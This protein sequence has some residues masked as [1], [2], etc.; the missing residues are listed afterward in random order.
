MMHNDIKEVDSIE[1]ITLMDNLSDPFTESHE[2]MRW[3]EAQYQTDIRHKRETCGTDL[4]RAC[5]G[6]SLY[7]KIHV[8]NK[9]YHL[10]FDTGPDQGLV[11][12]NAARLGIDLN[13]LD[14]IVIS[15]GHFDHYGG[16]LSVLDAIQKP[17]M[18]VYIHPELFSPRAW[19]LKNGEK[20]FDSYILTKAVVEAHG[21]KVIADK[22]PLAILNN[23][24]LISGE[25][26][27]N[28]GYEKGMPSEERFMNGQWEDGSL[29]I[30]ERTLIFKLKNK[31]LCIFTG[32]GHI[33]VVNACQHAIQLTGSSDIYLLMGGLH[34]ATT[35]TANR[36][37]PTVN[38]LV[39][40]N[41]QYIATGH[42][43]GARAQYALNQAF[44]D[45]H[46]PYGV[47]TVFR[48]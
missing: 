14:A 35:G 19:A 17:D 44:A 4:C 43:T 38:D 1:V 20:T 18:P 10:L 23:T 48:W 33:G 15:H 30:D 29:V 31:G 34:L 37:E 40:L 41:P 26:P 24:V 3:N 9:T 36:I 32:C 46:I 25:V 8:D 12:E 5:T 6:L 28:T 13:L 21:G 16:L 7:V 42:C 11:V 39:A 45:R 47:A 22:N 27:R 2:G